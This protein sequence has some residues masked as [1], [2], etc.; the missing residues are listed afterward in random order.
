M[1][2]KVGQENIKSNQDAN[3]FINMI[4]EAVKSLDFFSMKESIKLAIRTGISSIDIIRK[5]LLEG[6]QESGDMG[7]IL[8]A[9]VLDGELLIINEEQKKKLSKARNYSGKIVV[10][11]IQGDIHSLGKK[12]LIAL[13]K[14]YG[15]DVIDLGVD[16]KPI[17]FL[18]AAKLPNVKVIGISYLLSS[19]EPA[20]KKVMN[21]LKSDN[22]SNEI[23]IILGGAAVTREIAEETKVDAYTKDALEGVE[24]ID[25]WLRS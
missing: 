11:T 25:K 22:I 8:A 12:I 3:Y 17:Q 10:G 7:L 14:S 23:K 20:I 1:K 21:L 19:V 18:E 13:M 5:G 15:I 24:I 6:L 2:E 4:I 9:E 16:V